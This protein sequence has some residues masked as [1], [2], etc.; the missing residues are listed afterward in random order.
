MLGDIY[1]GV[2]RK[3]G[4]APDTTKTKS[5]TLTGLQVGMEVFYLQNK[6]LRE[7]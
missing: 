6:L 4:G 7:K 2:K 5:G 3:T 1:F